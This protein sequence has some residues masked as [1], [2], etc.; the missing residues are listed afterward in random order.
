MTGDPKK[1]ERVMGAIRVGLRYVR[2]APALRAVHG[3]ARR[4][5]DDPQRDVA[6]RRRVGIVIREWSAEDRR[7]PVVRTH[8]PAAG[9]KASRAA[10]ASECLLDVSNFVRRQMR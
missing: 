7:I 9:F 2:Y 4:L 8:R 5:L 10:P 6:Q 3:D 1:A